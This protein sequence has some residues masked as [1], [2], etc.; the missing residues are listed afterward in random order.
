MSIAR[1]CTLVLVV[2]GVVGM[3]WLIAPSEPQPKAFLNELHESVASRAGV[4]RI[5]QGF[6]H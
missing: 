4:E 2:V 3:V 6:R 1:F 5:F